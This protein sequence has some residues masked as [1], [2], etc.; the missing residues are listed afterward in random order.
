MI[1][2]VCTF[3]FLKVLWS[4]LIFYP[5][6]VVLVVGYMKWRDDDYIITPLLVKVVKVRRTDLVYSTHPTCSTFW[7]LFV[8][9]PWR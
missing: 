9:W 2:D 7:F 4:V 3:A 6:I 5:N 8:S 1:V